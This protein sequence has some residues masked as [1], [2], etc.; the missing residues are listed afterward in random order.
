MK[1]YPKYE[2]RI[3]LFN[4]KQLEILEEKALDFKIDYILK[5]AR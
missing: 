4:L 5:A 3:L 1:E 2:K